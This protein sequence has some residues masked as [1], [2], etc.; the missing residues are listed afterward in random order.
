MALD[1]AH[2]GTG[3][4]FTTIK[5]YVSG[6]SIAETAGTTALVKL[7][8]AVTPLGAPAACTDGAAGNVTVGLHNIAVT[9]VTRWGETVITSSLEFTA[10]GSK[11]GEITGV[12]VAARGAHGEFSDEIVGR[13]IYV[14]KAGAPATGIRP[15]NAQYFLVV[16]DASST[17]A[18][19]ENGKFLENEGTISVASGTDFAAAGGRCLVTTD[20]GPQVVKYTGKSTN[21]LTGCTT[22]GG[23][24]MSTG[25]AV[26]QPMLP[27][28]ITTT[29]SWN[30][31]DGSLT[32][33]TGPTKATAGRPFERISLQA[34]EST[35][36]HYPNPTK[37]FNG[38]NVYVEV[39][40]GTVA[41]TVR[42]A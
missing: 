32:A 8:D 31:A 11:K 2:V 4:E 17:L 5:S 18:A 21:D 34:N 39:T 33:T 14:S 22:L 30:V 37:L 35:S 38:G 41:W 19:A 40:S 26:T 25:G 16:A 24:V 27:D 20:R 1:I 6:F 29:Y 7:R 36:D 15:T 3:S 12:P 13:R 42:G 28:N 10:A 9:A 23:G